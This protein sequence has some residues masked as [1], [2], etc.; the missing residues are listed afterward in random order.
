MVSD[1]IPDAT[2]GAT[3]EYS[4]EATSYPLRIMNRQGCLAPC[5]FVQLLICPKSNPHCTSGAALKDLGM[6]EVKTFAVQF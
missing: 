6:Q 1:P 3:Y 2:G 4:G 5:G